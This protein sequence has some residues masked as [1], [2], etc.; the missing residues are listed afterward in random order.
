MNLHLIN[1]L[2]YIM[3]GNVEEAIIHYHALLL[4]SLLTKIEVLV[5]A[6]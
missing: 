3:F 6:N 2:F 5:E 4:F 1:Q